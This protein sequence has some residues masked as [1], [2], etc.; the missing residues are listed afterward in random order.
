MRRWTS[1]IN[2]RSSSAEAAMPRRHQGCDRTQSVHS[3]ETPL[4]RRLR[5]IPQPRPPRREQ[6]HQKGRP[7]AASLD[8]LIRP[9]QQRRRNR[10]AERLRGLEVD[11]QLELGGLLDGKISRLGALQDP[12]DVSGG[13]VVEF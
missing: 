9:Q 5:N 4:A 12:V 7:A 6:G 11:D 1:V 10:E 13:P 2:T 3:S 8:R